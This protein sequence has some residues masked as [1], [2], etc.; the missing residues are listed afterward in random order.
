MQAPLILNVEGKKCQCPGIIKLRKEAPE[1]KKCITS[2]SDNN[3]I[4]SLMR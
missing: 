4:S 1:I 3:E 2:K